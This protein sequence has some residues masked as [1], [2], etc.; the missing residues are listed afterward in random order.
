MPDPSSYH[1]QTK[2]ET[3]W[4]GLLLGSEASQE[5]PV[6]CLW[7]RFGVPVGA[8]HLRALRWSG[9]FFCRGRGGTG[10]LDMNLRLL[11]LGLLTLELHGLQVISIDVTVF[12]P[13]VSNAVALLHVIE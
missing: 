11:V 9:T 12:A 5:K 3:Y 8:Y 4:L 10:H 7:R 13:S 1:I 2:I 6:G